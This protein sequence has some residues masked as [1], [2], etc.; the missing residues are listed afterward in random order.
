M[1]AW[2]TGLLV[3]AALVLWGGN[4]RAQEEELE[5][6][7]E[8]LGAEEEVEA[9][10]PTGTEPE[11]EM[12]APAVEVPEVATSETVGVEEAVVE[13][14]VTAPEAPPS[15]EVFVEMP[16]E[17]EAAEAAE[18]GEVREEQIETLLPGPEAEAEEEVPAEEAEEAEKAAAGAPAE[19]EAA[20][21]EM[22]EAPAEERAVAPETE[23]ARRLAE[24][25]RIRRQALE[26]KGLKELIQ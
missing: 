1:R 18:A 4:L 15:A 12:A 14:E 8:D 5:S 9:A 24:Q 2:I 22:K 11:V 25:E 20:A 13:G 21:V 19:E 3:A 10:A 7:L 6:L 26:V 16:S 23:E 17:A